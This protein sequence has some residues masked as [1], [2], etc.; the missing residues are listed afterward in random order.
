[1]TTQTPTRRSKRFQPTVSI[2]GPSKLDHGHQWIEHLENRSAIPEDF[3]DPDDFTEEASCSFY[4]GFS[5]PT[6]SGR[7]AAS[8]QNKGKEATE[9]FRLGD[10]VLIYNDQ[11]A[12]NVAVIVALWEMTEDG[13]DDTVLNAR[14]QWF[15]RPKQLASVRVQKSYFPVRIPFLNP[16]VRAN[17]SSE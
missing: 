14:V 11:K 16:L 7:S 1:M 13:E 8:R 5:R 3:R 4:S 17:S 15:L 6:S 2:S 10:T 9:T 12:S